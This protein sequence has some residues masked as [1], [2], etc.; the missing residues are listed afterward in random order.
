MP[1]TLLPNA[2]WFRVAVPCREIADIPKTGPAKILFDLPE[3]HRLPDF[4]SL[5]GK[6]SWLDA[7][8][9]WNNRGLAFQFE[10]R[11]KQGAVVASHTPAEYADGVQLWIDT[12][13]ARDVHR[14]TK[15]CHRYF[16]SFESNVPTNLDMKVQLLK[17]HRA[18]GD[19]SGVRSEAVR[20]QGLALRGGWIVRVFLPSA[21]LHGYDPETNRRL[22]FTYQVTDA[23]CPPRWL[24]VGG[25][26][27]VAEDPS[28]WAT[29][30]LV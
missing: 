15:F 8:A 12:R 9:A 1:A 25:E 29:L 5:D 13:D 16:L 19:P 26:F 4:T 20:V 22:G 3:S 30:E 17:I 21:A 27:P 24:T 14:A 10:V 2:F 18:A 11:G 23:T 7:R 28:L 6:P